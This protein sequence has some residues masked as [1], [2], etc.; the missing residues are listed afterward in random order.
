[1]ALV[2]EVLENEGYRFYFCYGSLLGIVRERGMIGHDLDIDVAL[3]PADD[4]SWEHLN[5]VM[6]NAG[7]VLQRSFVIG[8][9]IKERTWFYNKVGVDI[10][11]IEHVKNEILSPFF[12]R[13]SGTEY[14]HK[15]EQGYAQVREPEPTG[16]T[17]LSIGQDNQTFE[18]NV[19]KNYEEILQANYGADWRTPNPHWS[20][21]QA[22][23]FE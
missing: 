12:F 19:P 11:L 6:T 21:W 9:D 16:I 1:M 20:C 18:V 3:D 22:V 5:Q 2:Q 10:F 13:K 23:F 17:K 4:F 8:D 7:F 14:E 15:L